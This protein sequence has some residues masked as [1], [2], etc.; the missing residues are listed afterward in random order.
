M[1]M[2]PEGYQPKETGSLQTLILQE[3]DNRKRLD[4]Y[5]MRGLE[6]G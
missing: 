4:S 2:A 3:R 1:Q 6:T 5:R